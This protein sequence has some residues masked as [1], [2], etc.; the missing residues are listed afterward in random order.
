M[1]LFLWKI[2]KGLNYRSLVLP[3]I[4]STRISQPAC[5]QKYIFQGHF[6][7]EMTFD[8]ALPITIKSKWVYDHQ[9][10]RIVVFQ[11]PLHC[12][13]RHKQRKKETLPYNHKNGSGRY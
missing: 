12:M 10:G 4:I 11:F 1:K 2:A 5:C 3:A 7:Y 13:I 9:A 6:S 8:K